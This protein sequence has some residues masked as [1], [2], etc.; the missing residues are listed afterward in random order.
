LSSPHKKKTQSATFLRKKST[1]HPDTSKIL[2]SPSSAVVVEDREDHLDTPEVKKKKKER[3]KETSS[4]GGALSKQSG[5]EVVKRGNDPSRR[6]RSL[7]WRPAFSWH[8][9]HHSCSRLLSTPNF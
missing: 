1:E 8:C 4:R 3:K 9:H 2:A 7:R 6:Q 5:Q